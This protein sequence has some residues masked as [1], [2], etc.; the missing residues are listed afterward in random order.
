MPEPLLAW[1][2][3]KADSVSSSTKRVQ[4]ILGLDAQAP[5]WREAL[6]VYLWKWADHIDNQKEPTDCF[7]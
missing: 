5:P 4:R 2:E 7:E 6:Y 1:Q 3:L